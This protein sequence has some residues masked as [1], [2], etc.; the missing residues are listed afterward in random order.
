MTSFRFGRVAACGLLALAMLAAPAAA[1]EPKRQ[2]ADVLVWSQ[3]ER[4][5]RFPQMET[6]FPHRT[7]AHGRKTHALP[8]GEPLTPLWQGAD[9]GLSLE[10]YMAAN[11][12]AGLLV[13]QDGKIRLERYGPTLGAKGH[14]A[15]FSVT[16]SITGTLY[17]AAIKDGYI[18]SLDDSVVAYLPEMKGSAYEGVSIRNLL[19]MTSGV[20]WSED[21]SNPQSEV[22]RMYGTPPDPGLDPIVSFMRHLPREAEPGTK[23]NYKTGETDLAGILLA[24]ATGRSLSAYLSEKIWRPYGMERDAIWMIDGRG[25]EAAGCCISMTL[26][27]YGR[28]GLFIAGGGKAGGKRIVPPWWTAEATKVQISNGQPPPA[29]YGYFWWIRPNG[30]YEAVGIFGQ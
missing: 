11:Q 21:Y 24:R 5:A 20:K 25:R 12:T 10:A 23:W 2:P 18:K 26:R 15:S 27:D 14:W 30:S 9:A 4:Q 13:I 19:T 28:V 7:I 8:M 3:A 29:G 16:K 17:G 6:L 22:A 1:A